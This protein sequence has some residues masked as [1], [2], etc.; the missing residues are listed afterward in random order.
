[1]CAL[2]G[3]GALFLIVALAAVAHGGRAA[4]SAQAGIEA[5]AVDPTIVRLAFTASTDAARDALLTAHPEIVTDAYVRAIGTTAY[6]GGDPE[7]LAESYNAYRTLIV[8]GIRSGNVR[9]RIIGLTG[10]GTLAGQRADFA[11][12]E[13][14]LN[15]ALALAEST[16]QA[17]QIIP[18]STNLGVVMRLQGKYDAAIASYRRSMA[19]AEKAGRR[20]MEARALTNLGIVAQ[21]QGDLRAALDYLTRSLVIKEALDQKQD[22]ANTL[23]SIGELHRHQGNL[24]LARADFDR[25]RALADAAP[26]R[27]AMSTALAGLGEIELLEGRHGSARELITRSLPAVRKRDRTRRGDEPHVRGDR[28]RRAARRNPSARLAFGALD[29]HSRRRDQLQ[30]GRLGTGARSD[31][32]LPR[33]DGRQQASSRAP[34]QSEPDDVHRQAAAAQYSSGI[35][36]KDQYCNTE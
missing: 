31:P 20:D 33:E 8:A 3:R 21:Q 5:P 9:L 17:E 16:G 22:L 1:M 18:A 19:V 14:A 34:P 35:G 32:A 24:A 10:V 23:L 2:M 36:A 25:A 28:S 12:A 30:F 6:R 27:S 26:L 4:A 15:E 29:H 7:N 11:L 13:P